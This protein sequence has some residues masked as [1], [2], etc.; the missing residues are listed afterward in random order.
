MKPGASFVRIREVERQAWDWLR[1]LVSQRNGRTHQDGLLPHLPGR[2]MLTG[3]GRAALRVILEHLTQDGILKNKNSQILVPQWLC[4]GVLQTMHRFCFPTLEA[5][6]STVG[7]LVYHQYGYPQRMD[8][9]AETCRRNHWIM[10]EDC[11]NVYDSSYQGQPLGSFGLASIFSFSKLFPSVLGGALVSSHQPLIQFCEQ[12]LAAR[13]PLVSHLSYASKWLAEYA[14]AGW[15]SLPAATFQAMVYGVIDEAFAM[16]PLS[17]RLIRAALQRGAMDARRRNYRQ[18]LDAFSDRPE[19]FAGLER[20]GVIPYVVPLFESVDRLEPMVQA[21][22]RINVVTGIYHFDVNRNLLN[23]RFEPCAWIPIHPGLNEER[24]AMICQSIR[25]AA[26][27]RAA[28][29]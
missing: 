27:S 10:I 11:A 3:T 15:L 23:P 18:L 8:E 17:L 22:R 25:D 9:I 1:V 4:Q 14:D 21:L 16:K 28:S 5:T 19:Y 29:A 7:V 6:A 2:V 12:R 20:D 26:A 13:A 24:M